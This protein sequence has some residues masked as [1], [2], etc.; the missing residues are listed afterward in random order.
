[1]TT[2]HVGFMDFGL[3]GF[4]VLGFQGSKCQGTGAFEGFTKL[5]WVLEG[6]AG[7]LERLVIQTHLNGL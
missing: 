7:F 2:T 5:I 1:M 6:L 3:E 4:G